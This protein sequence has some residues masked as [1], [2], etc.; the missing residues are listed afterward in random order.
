MN[1]CDKPRGHK[2]ARLSRSVGLIWGPWGGHLLRALLECS[3]RLGGD[4]WVGMFPC[5]PSCPHHVSTRVPPSG[6][7]KGRCYC[8]RKRQVS[9][10]GCVSTVPSASSEPGPRV[11]AA[12]EEAEA[13]ILWK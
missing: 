6:V 4:L 10:S 13:T 1:C 3:S 9:P 5:P 11:P 8:D 2:R 12:G 7:N